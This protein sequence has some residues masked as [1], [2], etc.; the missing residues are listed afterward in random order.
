MACCGLVQKY[1]FNFIVSFLLINDISISWIIYI[2]YISSAY[3]MPGSGLKDEHG[4]FCSQ[5]AHNL[6]KRRY[7]T[8][9]YYSIISAIF[10][11]YV[12]HKR[13]C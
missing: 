2:K 7:A 10:D 13:K 1:P 8:I 3:H 6:T 5:A 4:S 11:V 12:R 9:I